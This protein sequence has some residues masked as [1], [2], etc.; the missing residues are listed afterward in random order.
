[1]MQAKLDVMGSRVWMDSRIGYYVSLGV[2][3]SFIGVW[4]ICASRRQ[5]MGVA[6]LT[7]KGSQSISEVL[8]HGYQYVFD[9]NS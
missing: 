4:I 6:V 1:M 8:G 5:K 2:M 3:G 9:N 7:G